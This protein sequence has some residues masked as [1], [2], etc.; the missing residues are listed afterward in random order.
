MNQK[1]KDETL[2]VFVEAFHEV[3]VPVLEGLATKE[4][5]EGLATKEDVKEIID[6]RMVGVEEKISDLDDK[7]EMINRRLITV[8][9]H[10]AERIDNHETRIGKI[11]GN[12]NN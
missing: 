3:I 8:T 10:Q 11:E 7:V 4:D 5:L 1:Q 12:V 6:E 2:E 9:D